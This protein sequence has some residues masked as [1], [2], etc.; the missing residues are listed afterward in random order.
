M[1]DM[2]GDGRSAMRR[3][4]SFFIFHLA[5]GIP[6]LPTSVPLRLCVV[7]VFLTSA[8][9]LAA[10]DA[11]RPLG[12][13]RVAAAEELLAANAGS[14]P[15]PPAPDKA[16]NL[17]YNGSFEH[18]DPNGIPLGW[19]GH[20]PSPTNVQ[21]LDGPPGRGK[22]VRLYG[23]AGRMG[24]PGVFC[25]QTGDIPVKANT[26]YRCTGWTKSAGPTFIIFV[27]GFGLVRHNVGD[28]TPVYEEVYMMKKEIAGPRPGRAIRDWEPFNLDFE[29]RPL[30]VFSDFQHRVEFVR[31]KIFAYWP[32]GTCWADDF[33]FFEVGPVPEDQR[34]LADAM[35]TAGLAPNLSPPDPNEG[36]FDEEQL[37]VDAGNAWKRQEYARCHFL[38]S[39]LVAAVPNKGLYRLLLARAAA[40]LMKYDEAEQQARWVLEA[41]EKGAA[42]ASPR[43]EV[44]AWMFDWARLVHAEAVMRAADASRGAA[45]LK[46]LIERTDSPHVKATAQKLLAQAE[47]GTPDTRQ[48]ASPEGGPAVSDGGGAGNR[49]PVEDFS[50]K[51]WYSLGRGGVWKV[52]N[53]SEIHQLDADKPWKNNGYNRKLDQSGRMAWEFDILLDN[54]A[55]GAGIYVMADD[56]KANDRGTSYLLWYRHAKAEEGKPAHGQMVIGKFV[57]N[58]RVKDWRVTFD[59]PVRPDEWAR[60]RYEYDPATGKFNLYCQGKPAGQATDPQPVKSGNHVSLHSCLTACKWRNLRIIHLGK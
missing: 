37:Y 42:G 15:V 41:E 55:C 5:F 59:V 3:R 46:A 38:S 45:L 22:V 12:K 58:R 29:V 20:P 54:G 47:G 49:A 56:E 2:P 43:R 27:K 51:A 39:Q 60:L 23:D 50:D 32:P 4:S 40:A 35:T 7:L 6:S 21:V 53:R 26:R 14:P 48:K 57:K 11:K 44:E 34:I 8:A 10:D 31:V 17:I 24:A 36:K 13:G 1:P 25:M 28:R 9:A 30:R 16:L 33:R 18:A 19:R 52:V